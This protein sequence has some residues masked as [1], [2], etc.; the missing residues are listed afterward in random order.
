MRIEQK[1]QGTVQKGLGEHQAIK[2]QHAFRDVGGN[3]TAWSTTI[4]VG[5]EGI[6]DLSEPHDRK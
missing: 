1:S 5:P 2:V 3:K 6:T 4:P